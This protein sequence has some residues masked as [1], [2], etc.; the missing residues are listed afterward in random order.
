MTRYAIQR[1]NILY[2]TSTIQILKQKKT[3]IHKRKKTY[4][5]TNFTLKYKRFEL[6]GRQMISL[7]RF[8]YT[9]IKSIKPKYYKSIHFE[10]NLFEL[11]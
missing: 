1:T 2:Q 11:K 5:V 6:I 10:N 7:E 3:S 4:V 8:Y 9:I